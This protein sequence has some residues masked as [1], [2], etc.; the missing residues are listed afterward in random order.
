MF[1][2]EQRFIIEQAIAAY[3]AAR[4]HRAQLEQQINTVVPA[5][6]RQNMTMALADMWRLVDAA[7]PE[8]IKA[9]Y[10]SRRQSIVASQS[11]N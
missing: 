5:A 10:K 2:P 8:Y 11:L 7:V 9:E 1:T 6:E 3:R 4:Q